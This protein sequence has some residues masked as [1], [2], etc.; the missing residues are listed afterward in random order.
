MSLPSNPITRQ[1]QYLSRIAGEETVIPDK[2]ITRE[3]QYLDYIARNG[4]GGITVDEEMS[5]SS[6]NPVQ[7]KVITAAIANKAD[8][9]D[10][11]VPASQLPSY[12]DDIIEGYYYNDAFYEDA[13]H[14]TEIT[15]ETGKIYIDLDTNKSYRWSGSVYVEIAGGGSAELS[16]SLT[17]AIEVGGIDAGTTYAAGTALETVLRDMLEPTLYPTLV[18]PSAT[19]SATGD[20]IMEKG[21][22]QSVT[23]T[24]TFSRGSIT[25]AYGTNGYRSGEDY[26]YTLYVNGSPY[27]NSYEG[28]FT[29]TVMENKNIFKIVVSY[30]AGQ[31]P[32]DSKGNNYD[33]PL[34]AGSVDTSTVTYN[35]VYAMW[36]NTSNIATVA[37]LSLINNATT[38]Q[39][40]MVFP[41]QT[42][43]NPEV[44]DIPASW[45]VTA[46]Q[47]KND[48]SG[49][50][51]DASSQFTVTDT[52]HNDAAGNSVNYKRYTFNMGMATGQRT[53]RVKWS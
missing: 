22:T 45:T 7:N 30:L 20:K 40:D 33:S 29:Y 39:R 26:D 16:A 23:I 13:Q 18:D 28:Y 19:I 14:T 38:K 36:A 34:P 44:F 21:A 53:V 31:Q 2:P 35:F 3:E 9:I 24:S 17:S 52:T 43:S 27:I 12:V 4:S 6:T 41:A 32:K 47:V 48:L 15:G 1:E 5:D 51:E 46:V 10:G 37:K 50:Y 25:P 42:V 49:Q 8:L 11:K